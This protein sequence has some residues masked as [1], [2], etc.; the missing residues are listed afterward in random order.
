LIREEGVAHI[1]DVAPCVELCNLGGS[2][3]NDVKYGVK[4]LE[5]KWALE[6]CGISHRY[7]GGK[8]QVFQAQRD[9]ELIEKASR[10]LTPYAGSEIPSTAGS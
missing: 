4:L 1:G 9:R 2:F 8:L 6:K 10:D 7:V 5:M 3:E